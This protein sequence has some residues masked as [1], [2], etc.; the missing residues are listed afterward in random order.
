MKIL[1]AAFYSDSLCLWGETD[2]SL[3]TGRKRAEKKTALPVLSRCIPLSGL[4]ELCRLTGCGSRDV[5]T[6]NL[7]A[8]IPALGGVPVPSN[9]LLGDI[10]SGNVKIKI[11]P[12]SIPVL[13]LN[14]TQTFSLFQTISGNEMIETGLFA[15]IDLRFWSRALRLAED[16]ILSQNFLPGIRKIAGQP[17]AFWYPFFP[18]KE[19]KRFQS[20][21]AEMPGACRAVT[22]DSTNCPDRSTQEVLLGFLTNIVDYR[23]RTLSRGAISYGLSQKKSFDSIHDQ[24][25]HALCSPGKPM[26]GSNSEIESFSARIA[27]WTLPLRAARDATFRLCFRLEDPSENSGSW[28]VNYF[29]QPADDPSLLVPA[30]EVWRTRSRIA[31]FLK[32]QIESPQEKLLAGLGQAARVCPE[33]ESSLRAKHPCGYDMD[34]NGAHN[35]LMQQ[36]WLLE[37]S[38]FSVLFPSWWTRKGSK[39]KVTFRAKVKSPKLIAAAGMNSIIHFDWEL[40]LGDEKL[41]LEELQALAKLKAPLARIRGQWVQLNPEEIEQ[42]MRFWKEKKAAETTLQEVVRMALGAGAQDA[43]FTVDGVEASGWIGEMLSRLQGKASLKELDI[44]TFFRGELRPYQKRGYWWLDFLKSWGLGACLADDMGLGKTVQTLAL[45]QRD[46]ESSKEKTVLLVCPTSVIGNWQ[47]EASRFTPGL[48]VLVHHGGTRTR[49]E[50]FKKETTR[51]AIVLCSYALLYRDL[52]MLQEISWKGVILDEAQNIKNPETKQA[53]AARSLV[54]DYRIALTGT[55]VENNIGDLWS[56][57]EFLNPGFLGTQ[58]NFKQR[59]F[60]P[61]QNSRDQQALDQLKQITGPFILRRLKTDKSIIADL[62]EKLEMKVFCN[63]TKEQASLYAAVLS[64]ME[65]KIEES[66]GMERKG[67]ILA[68]LSKLKQVCNHPAQFLGDRSRIEGRSGKLA[69]LTE[70]LEEAIAAGDRTLIFTQFVEMGEILKRHLLENFGKEVLFLHG[71]VTKNNRDRMIERFQ[72]EDGG[73]QIFLLS[74]KAGGTGLNLTRANHVFHF[75]RWWNPAVENQATDRAFR[76][77]QKRNVQVHKFI[78]IGTLEERIDE[79]IERK[80]EVAEKIISTGEGWLTE[81][82][83]EQLK[84]LFALRKDAVGE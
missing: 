50:D 43:N 77:G 25:L 33:I 39:S 3:T 82:S 42:A 4:R 6:A 79:M 40:A 16:L 75:D 34:L 24:W 66:E 62:P 69:R 70:M 55:P 76:I 83:N 59:F 48:S 29:L 1:H 11:E 78:C 36:A 31:T 21:A 57:M 61:I 5:K 65:E 56:L 68:T 81:M 44:S 20:L 9:P 28:H 2:A 63:L 52:P 60:L 64:N 12:W 47:K 72:N 38:G 23:V 26:T 73:P 19:Q 74:L 7:V 71:Q 53:R 35:F 41:S 15:G 8:W 10:P 84:N 27:E 37:Q 17:F 54:C 13:R 18:D 14:S 51:H 67:M 46:R 49:G 58:Q 22:Q 30:E 80:K 32:R 45:I